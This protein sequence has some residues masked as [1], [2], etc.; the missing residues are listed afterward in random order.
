MS[1]MLVPVLFPEWRVA[2]AGLGCAPDQMGINRHTG[3][4]GR[5]Q[6]SIKAIGLHRRPPVHTGCAPPSVSPPTV[7]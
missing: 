7:S 4:R 1:C 6:F 3:S 5:A 2:G